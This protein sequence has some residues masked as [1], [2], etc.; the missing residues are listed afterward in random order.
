M[1]HTK[2]EIVAASGYEYNG[3]LYTTAKEARRARLGDDLRDALPRSTYALGYDQHLGPAVDKIM[4]N[5]EGVL[6]A[7]KRFLTNA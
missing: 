6:N 2:D 4:R 7:L 3:K 5:P 1:T